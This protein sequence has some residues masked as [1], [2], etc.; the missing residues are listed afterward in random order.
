M[1][2]LLLQWRWIYEKLRKLKI[3][4]GAN[5][6]GIFKTFQRSLSDATKRLQ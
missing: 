4:V 5:L 1:I 6:I 2:T 3:P